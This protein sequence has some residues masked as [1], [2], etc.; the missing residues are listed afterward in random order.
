[1]KKKS[2]IISCFIVLSPNVNAKNTLTLGDVINIYT[3]KNS[4]IISERLRFENEQLEYENYKKG[5]LPSFQFDLSP[6]SF[7]RSMRLLQDPYSGNYSNVEDYSNT[8]S[9]GLSMTQKVG[10]TNGTLTASSSLSL[11]REFSRGNNSFSST[12]FY[13][14]YSQSLWGGN[15]QYKYT[16]DI[17]HLQHDIAEK[18]F[19]TSIS[20]EQQ[21]VLSLYL[22]AY[23]EL[24]KR[25][26]A[27]NNVEI[28]D[29]LLE[30][31]KLKRANGYITDY[32]YNQVELQQLENSYEQEHASQNYREA[33]LKLKDRLN[34]N[35]EMELEK[36]D[37][38]ELP[39]ILD[40]GRVTECIYRNNPQALND[41]LQRKQAAYKRYTSR[42]AT[43]MNGTVS[44]NYGLNQY[45]SSLK[46]AYY[47]PDSRQAVSISFS[48]PA[49]EWGINHNKRK[50]ADNEYKAALLDLEMTRKT[51]DEQVLTQVMD[52]NYTH[53]ML[54][55]AERSY[56]L[57][58][59]QYRLA[60]QKFKYGKISVYE[61]TSAETAQQTA[62][63]QYYSTLQSLFSGYYVLRHLALYDFKTDRELVEVFKETK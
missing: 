55:I 17:M 47:K 43:F 4:T 50:I 7:N 15:K 24:L 32:E 39:D 1:M 62:M 61:L 2:L 3:L 12:P 44:V 6:L 16:R 20:S 52:Y 34:V 54:K 60:A 11:L 42:M 9:A 35:A 5:F 37:V 13:I 46:G 57:S 25:Q 58:Q 53:N 59:E 45:A 48:I 33:I 49:F 51:F 23:S 26:L 56:S 29:T 40:A 8:S 63:Q 38:R 22:T 10:S 19:C 41:E 21:T 18:N 14:S 27:K 28:G 30:F 31:A 36:P